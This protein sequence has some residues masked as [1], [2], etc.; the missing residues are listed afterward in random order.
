MEHLIDDGNWKRQTVRDL[1][2]NGLMY[3]CFM[4]MIIVLTVFISFDTNSETVV[5]IDLLQ[6]LQWAATR[7]VCLR[8]MSAEEAPIRIP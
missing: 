6:S 7:I 5:R 3:G 4:L 1:S 2:A 8:R